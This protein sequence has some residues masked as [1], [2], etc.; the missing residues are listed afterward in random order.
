MFRNW[1]AAHFAAVGPTIIPFGTH[2][3]LRTDLYSN[4]TNYIPRRTDPC[5]WPWRAAP[6]HFSTHVHDHDEPHRF[7]FRR[8]GTHGTWG[9]FNPGTK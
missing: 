8:H 5:P 7:I 1:G 4:L 3:L 9:S 2:R 6:L